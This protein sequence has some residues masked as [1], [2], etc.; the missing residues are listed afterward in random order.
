LDDRA[1]YGEKN[2]K[3]KDNTKDGTDDG[4]NPK[5]TRFP[6]RSFWGLCGRCCANIADIVSG[7]DCA[8]T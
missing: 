8:L 6:E 2:D 5:F 7:R 4:N 3:Q 1:D